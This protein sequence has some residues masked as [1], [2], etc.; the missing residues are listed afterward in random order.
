MGALSFILYNHSNPP[1]NKSFT[2]AF[3]NMKNRGPNDSSYITETST[4]ITRFNED[5]VRMM[6]SK[7]EIAEYKPFTY[8]YGFHRLCVNDLSLDGSQPFRDPIAHKIRS[9]PELGDR[10]NR[11]LICNGEIYNYKELVEQEEFTDKDIQSTCDVEVIMPMYIKYGLQETLKRING[12]F[13][14]VLMENLNTYDLKTTNIFVV[15]D[16]LGA[17]PLYMVKSIKQYYYMFTSELKG[18]PDSILK[19]PDYILSEVPPGTFWSFQNSIMDKAANEFIRYSDWNFYR[20]LQNCKILSAEPNIIANLYEEVYNLIN[21]S[22]ITRY[23]T[24]DVAVGVLLSGG[25][26]SSIILSLLVHYLVSIGHNFKASPV[27]AFTIGDY[28]YQS[29]KNDAESSDTI[30]AQEC[31]TFLEQKFGIE[32][33]HHIVSA[34]DCG[35]LLQESNLQDLIYTLETYDHVTIRAAIPMAAI[36]SYIRQNTTVRVLLTGEGLD[37]LCGYHQLFECDDATFQRKS[38]KLLKNLSKYDLLRADK[39]SGFYGLE[40]RH[41]FL[42]KHVIEYLLQVH[43]KLKRPQIFDASMEP[44]EKYIVRKAF[45]QDLL[46]KSVLWRPMQDVSYAFADLSS[47]LQA[48]V[49]SLNSSQKIVDYSQWYLEIY[50][51]T[52]SDSEHLLPCYWNDL[53]K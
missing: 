17:K 13:S 44:I 8:I 2:D 15:R 24:S 43:P 37:E 19:D 28:H 48:Y 12:D 46:P 38:V 3:M 11:S 27:Y 40:L 51:I 22:V 18:I 53:W 31:V 41:P 33:V 16:I 23:R 29:T 35:L 1:V 21:K 32:I 30:S 7:R 49:E 10:P 6:L 50:N 36:M 52:F 34:V 4:P 26:D 25:F 9:Y 20:D 5:Q 14:F 47:R 42:D 39:L 45:D